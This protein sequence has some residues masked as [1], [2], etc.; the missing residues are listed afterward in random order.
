IP[1]ALALRPVPLADQL[2]SPSPVRP[3]AP[4]QTSRAQLGFRD[5]PS[6]ESTATSSPRAPA[7]AIPRPRRLA[8]RRPSRISA[9]SPPPPPPRAPPLSVSTRAARRSDS[10]VPGSP[11]QGQGH[12]RRPPCRPATGSTSIL[13]LSISK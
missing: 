10:G 11:I 6:P 8:P 5:F 7:G 12:T 13:N 3:E 2:P 9:A 4:D 1:T